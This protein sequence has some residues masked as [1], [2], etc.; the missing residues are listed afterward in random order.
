MRRPLITSAIVYLTGLILGGALDYFPLTVSAIVLMV[1]WAVVRVCRR[2]FV[3]VFVLMLMIS[4]VIFGWVRMQMTQSAPSAGDLGTFNTRGPVL[5]EGVIDEPLRRDRDRSTMFLKVHSVTINGLDESRTHPVEGRLRV[6]LRGIALMAQYGDVVRIRAKLRS[7]S[8]MQNPGGFDYAKHLQRQGIRAVT[9]IRKPEAITRISSGGFSPLRQIYDWREEIRLLLVESLPPVS[10]AILQ[11]MLIGETLPLA[12]SVRESFAYAGAA[13][14]LSIS[15][16]H[17]AMVAWVVFFISRRILLRM[18]GQ[19]L[20]QFSRRLSVTKMAVLITVFPVVFYTLLAGGRIPTL[21]AMI[22]I[23]IYLAAVWM[24]RSDDSLNALAVAALVVLVWDPLALFSISF[25]LSYVAVFA[26]LLFGKPKINPSGHHET[27]TAG[28][29]PVSSCLK[30]GFEKIRDL[31]RISFIAGAASFPLTAYHFNQVSWAGFIANPIVVPLVGLLIVP[32][33]LFCAIGGLLFHQTTLPL[34]GV[35]DGLTQGLMM[36]VDFFSGL[37]GAGMHV[38]SPPVIVVTAIY[39][40]VLAAVLTGAHLLKICLIGLS[41]LVIIVWGLRMS[42]GP[43]KGQ[44][45][46]TFFDVGQGDAAW[47]R[48]PDGKTMLIDGGAVYGN[49]DVGRFAIAPYLW[50][51]GHRRIDTMVASHPQNDHMGGLAYLI[52]KFDIGEIWTNG[53]EKDALFF[54]RFREAARAKSVPERKVLADDLVIYKDDNLELMILHPD[55][56]SLSDTTRSAASD[57]NRSLVIRLQYGREV[58]LFTGDIEVSAQRELLRWGD[59]LGATVLKVPHH[60]SR[61]SIDPEFL[62][63]VAPSIAVIS[64]GRSN[65]YRH[66]SPETIAAYGALGATVYRTDRGGAVLYRTDGIRRSVQRYDD[67]TPIPVVWGGDM[68]AMEESNFSKMIKRYW[69]GWMAWP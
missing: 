16:T 69:Y 57:N 39:L 44:L 33:G 1:G 49:F 3:S 41:L 2:R 5:I 63:R 10:S 8:G 51:T 36:I 30:L 59:K 21:R 19:W 66:P 52:R 23:L 34:A 54:E 64:V 37:P 9:S 45:Y 27:S 42:S 22:M 61:S 13:H 12:P 25:Q 55:F 68:A 58:L 46:V 47:I 56:E 20:L 67:I 24:E 62:Y 4:L 48:M 50:N 28:L 65:P 14:L 17:L 40:A 35:L 7:V 32:L 38:P 26:I 43:E 53:T 18:P 11:A 31:F 29:S 6:T 15:G 60:G